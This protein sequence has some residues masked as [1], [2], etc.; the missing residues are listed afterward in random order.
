MQEPPNS[1]IIL[2]KKNKAGEL[3]LSYFKN[4]YKPT[5]IKTILLQTYNNKDNVVLSQG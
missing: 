5:T 3:I 1:K 4:Y 2:E